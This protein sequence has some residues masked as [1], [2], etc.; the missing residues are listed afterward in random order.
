MEER[1]HIPRSDEDVAEILNVLKEYSSS[2]ISV[3][4]EYERTSANIRFTALRLA[5]SVLLVASTTPLAVTFFN[6]L[7]VASAGG[8]LSVSLAI[9]TI[10]VIVGAVIVVTSYVRLRSYE[11]ERD[12]LQRQ[13][14]LVTDQ[15]E[16][17]IRIGTQI[18]ELQS[19][20]WSVR[21]LLLRLRLAEAEA[22]YKRLG[23]VIR[24]DRSDSSRA[25]LSEAQIR[26]T[27][28]SSSRH[29]T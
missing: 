15:L 4:R 20:S 14:D 21:G 17:V 7:L 26:A 28:S 23:L 29:S 18:D 6:S 19:K 24:G 8:S 5:L 11:A 16:V 10:A 12:E 2:L 25:G 3:T 9:V 1:T 13:I 22:V 27:R